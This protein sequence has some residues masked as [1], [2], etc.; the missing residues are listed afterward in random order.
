MLLERHRNLTGA[1]T[2]ACETV[3]SEKLVATLSLWHELREKCRMGED[4]T[5]RSRT[6]FYRGGRM[7]TEEPLASDACKWDEDE[8]R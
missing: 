3:S 5:M 7:R 8:E 6:N 1:V 2:C 4:S